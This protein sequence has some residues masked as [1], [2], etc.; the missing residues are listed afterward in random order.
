MKLEIFDFDGTLIKSPQPN[1]I[2]NV[3]GIGELPA[4]AAYERWLIL[5]KKR[6][7]KLRG[8]NGNSETLR[9]PIFPRPLQEGMVNRAVADRFLESK[10]NSDVRTVIMTGRHV[11]LSFLVHQILLGYNLLTADEISKQTVETRFFFR[12]NKNPNSLIWKKNKITEWSESHFSIEIW[13]DREDHYQ[14][15]EELLSGMDYL[16]YYHVHK[17]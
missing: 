12:T 17:V 1:T 6:P 9:H 14:A 13:E 3:P 10:H 7:K 15:F 4:E 8:W 11:G 2:I 5:N 16:D